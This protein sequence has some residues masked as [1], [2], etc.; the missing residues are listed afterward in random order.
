MATNEE[1]RDQVIA[2]IE[3][4]DLEGPE[5]VADWA[6][7]LLDSHGIEAAMAEVARAEKFDAAADARRLSRTT[8]R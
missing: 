5:Q 1:L 2:A 3:A 6:L 4:A 8:A 7:G